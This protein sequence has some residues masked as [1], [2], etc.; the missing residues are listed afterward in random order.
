M[1]IRAVRE[2]TRMHSCI[3]YTSN[4]MAVGDALQSIFY[5]YQK[6]KWITAKVHLVA[7]RWTY[8]TRERGD[9]KQLMCKTVFKKTAYESLTSFLKS[10][11][12]N[13]SLCE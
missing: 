7:G 2:R 9:R 10:A 12:E 13:F 8:F 11:W 6:G 1:V 5:W 3:V 4:Y